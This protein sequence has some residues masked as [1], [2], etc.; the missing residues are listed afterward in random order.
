MSK[1]PWKAATR[2]RHEKEPAERGPNGNTAVSIEPWRDT[3]KEARAKAKAH[4]GALLASVLWNVASQNRKE[5]QARGAP[6]YIGSPCDR[7]VNAERYT[8]TGHCVICSRERADARRGVPTRELQTTQD[9]F[10][11]AIVGTLYS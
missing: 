10:A 1:R 3:R 8:S 7:H 2:A 4:T 5:A 6:R 9:D 11:P